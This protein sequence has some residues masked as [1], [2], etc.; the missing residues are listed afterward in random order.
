[1]A[2]ILIIDDDPAG[3]LVLREILEAAG[4]R[5][6]EAPDGEAGVRLYRERLPDLVTTNIYMPEKDG[7]ETIKEL[8]QDFPDAK[9]IAISGSDL[10]GRFSLLSVAREFGAQRALSKPFARD[11]ILK[12]VNELLGE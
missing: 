12:A 9:I 7:I 11:E 6:V 2:S 10:K 3:R 1:M 5:V 8:K 4:H